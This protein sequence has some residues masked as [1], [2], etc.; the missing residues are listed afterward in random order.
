MKITSH[1]LLSEFACRDG[2]PYPAEWIDDRLTPLCD[3]L[4]VVRAWFGRRVRIVSGYRTLAYNRRIGGALASQHPEGRAA[5]FTVAGAAPFTVH[6]AVLELH[7]SGSLLERGVHL[8]GLGAY[9]GF[10]HVDVRQ[11][12][13][14]AR[15]GGSRS[16]G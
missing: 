10:T 4:E 1:F 6:A 14:L 3:L 8:G 9:P 16:V 2:T 12:N 5:D 7:R 13:R 15:W 11:G